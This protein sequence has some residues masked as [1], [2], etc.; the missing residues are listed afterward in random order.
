MACEESLQTDKEIDD[1]RQGK[2]TADKKREK[3]RKNCQKLVSCE[4]NL[5]SP[6]NVIFERQQSMGIGIVKRIFLRDAKITMLSGCTHL[7]TKVYK[8]V[9]SAGR[10]RGRNVI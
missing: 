2:I 1:K 4:P 7:Y 5:S 8:L 9:T 10:R 6:R 3:I